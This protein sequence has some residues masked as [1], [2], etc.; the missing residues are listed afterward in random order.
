MLPGIGPAFAQRIIDYRTANGAFA[1]VEDLTEVKGIGPAKLAQYGSS[2]L[3]ILAGEADTEVTLSP[4][5]AS[6]EPPK[7]AGSP[8]GSLYVAG[9]HARANRAR[10]SGSERS[11]R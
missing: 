9:V 8:A 11:D 5:T 4:P 3:A 1:R 6:A 2:L 10:A 7:P